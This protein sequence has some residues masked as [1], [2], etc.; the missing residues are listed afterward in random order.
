MI[1]TLPFMVNSA[2]LSQRP[3]PKSSTPPVLLN[4]IRIT[5]FEIQRQLNFLIKGSITSC[6][7]V[8]PRLFSPRPPPVIEKISSNGQNGVPFPSICA[9]VRTLLHA[10]QRPLSQVSL[11][12]MTFVVKMRLLLVLLLVTSCFP[13]TFTLSIL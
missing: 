6:P 5:P 12:S 4:L 11:P 3:S 2:L 13:C 1:L 8:L 10:T 7:H 9:T